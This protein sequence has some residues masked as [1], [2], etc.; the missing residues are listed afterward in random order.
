MILNY[1]LNRSCMQ[2]NI[3]LYWFTEK[4]IKSLIFNKNG[5]QFI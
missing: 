5:D 3:L 4:F 1:T 2:G